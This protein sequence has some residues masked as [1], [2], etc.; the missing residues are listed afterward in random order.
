VVNVL[1]TSLDCEAADSRHVVDVVVV[2]VPADRC[3]ATHRDDGGSEPVVV[4][5]EE[6]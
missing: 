6:E 1:A 4:V 3:E 5:V 2:V